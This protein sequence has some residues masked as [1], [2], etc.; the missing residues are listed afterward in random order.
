[1]TRPRTPPTQSNP[2]TESRDAAAT[3]AQ[4]FWHAWRWWLTPALVSL[5][6]AII[7]A[8]PFAGDWDAIDYI[9]LALRG[10]P[11][12]MAFG[13]SLFIYTN[14]A[15]WLAAHTLFHLRAENAYLL[16]KY[17]VVAETPFAIILCWLL[18]RDLTRSVYAATIAALFITASPT[19]VVYSGQAMTEIPFV[20][21]TMA[22]LVVHLRGLQKHKMWL[23]FSGAALL[24]A[25]VNVR[26]AA[27]F[28]APWLVFA[29]FVCGWKRGRREVVIVALSCALFL[30]FA[31]GVFAFLFAAD[32]FSYRASWFS[33]RESLIME[34][35]RHP[36][37]WHNAEVFLLFFFVASPLVA[38]VLPSAVW[39][40]W[41]RHKLSL[42]LLLACVGFLADALLFFNYSTT[43]NWR[44]FLTGLPALAPL[45]ADFLLRVQTT[46]LSSV[47]RAFWSVTLATCFV[48]ALFAIYRKPI[49]GENLKN[50]ALTKNYIERLRLLPPDAVVI[51]GAQTVGVTYWRGLGAGNWDVI[52][53]GG[54]WPGKEVSSIIEKYLSTGRRVFVDTDSRL[55]SACG[56]QVEEARE[57]AAVES[58][59][60]FRRISETIYEIRSRAD[61]TARDVPNLQSLLPENRPEDAKQCLGVN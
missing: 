28:Y 52:G 13:R 60:H 22:A 51:A 49:A 10:Q 21:L 39:S 53:T 47:R 50:R 7:F 37:R 34:A 35:A 59:F 23:V 5:L 57:L 2:P 9:I 20:L 25:C 48:A 29:P 26:E 43:I 1:L 58:Q 55:W 16:F 15:L 3:E 32:A 18:A 54:G 17:T 40:E 6:L 61:E 45:A 12:S 4:S 46:K 31:L 41:K 42:L 11:S 33:W 38:I 44:Y 14:H 30:L 36:L 24:G 8:D 19:F 56:W 27:A